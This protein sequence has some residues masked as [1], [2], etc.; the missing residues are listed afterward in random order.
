MVRTLGFQRLKVALAVE[1]LVRAEDFYLNTLDLAPAF[2]G[3]RQVGF[4]LGDV[5]VMLKPVKDGWYARPGA[6]LNPRVTIATDD[7]AHTES[8]LRARGVTIS[9]P[10][11][12]Y[13]DVGF[14]V[15]RFLDSEGNRIWFCSPI[16]GI[17]ESGDE[18]SESLGETFPLSEIGVYRA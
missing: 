16:A 10:V 3:E 8:E 6:Q 14:Y 7:A 17:E 9:D 5:I 1:D 13:P 15:G 11:E 12:A 4:T 18:S 2:E